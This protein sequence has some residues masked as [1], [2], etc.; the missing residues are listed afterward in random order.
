[1]SD[2][3]STTIQSK[4]IEFIH[5]CIISKALNDGD[6]KSLIAKELGFSR[7][8][9]HNEIQRGTIQH[10][11]SDLTIHYVYDPYAAEYK[12]K[13]ASSWKGRLSILDDCKDLAPIIEEGVR[14]KRSPEV[15]AYQINQLYS[16]KKISHSLCF[17]TIYNLIE[18]GKLSV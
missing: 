4:N 7:Q 3:Y 12:H 15:I 18:S 14:N 6:S 1:M 13:E 8:T 11:N 5:R 17:K 16:E 2:Y 10:M 9:I